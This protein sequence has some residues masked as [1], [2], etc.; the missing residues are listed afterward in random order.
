MEGAGGVCVTVVSFLFTLTMIHF[1]FSLILNTESLLSMN[2]IEICL[3][4]A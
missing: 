3:T 2:D 4:A 1:D